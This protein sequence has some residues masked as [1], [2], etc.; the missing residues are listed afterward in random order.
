MCI[1]DRVTGEEHGCHRPGGDDGGHQS[2]TMAAIVA[3]WAVAAVLL[4][5]YLDTNLNEPM[6]PTVYLTAA[7]SGLAAAARG[8][9]WKRDYRSRSSERSAMTSHDSTATTATRRSPVSE[10]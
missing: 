10:S 3:A 8:N 2:R 6:K 1:R 4:A 7:L 5:G 9:A